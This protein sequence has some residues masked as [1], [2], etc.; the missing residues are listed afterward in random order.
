[1]TIKFQTKTVTVFLFMISE[2]SIY[3]G[4]KNQNDKDLT[5]VQVVMKKSV[6]ME[7]FFK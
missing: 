2:T 5:T 6:N 4:K 3:I 1:M 7:S